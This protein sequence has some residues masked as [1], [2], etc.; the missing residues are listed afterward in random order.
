MPRKNLEI[1]ETIRQLVEQGV[2]SDVIAAQLNT[3]VRQVQRLRQDIGISGQQRIIFTPEQKRQIELW[4]EDEVPLAEIA[5][6]LGV[7]KKVIQHRYRGRG[8]G[9][10]GNLLSCRKLMAELGLGSWEEK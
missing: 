2:S 3:S 1:R 10:E 4:L 8:A 9:K 7:D 6:S 5:R